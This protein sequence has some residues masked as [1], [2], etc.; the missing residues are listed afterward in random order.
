M[1]H[2]VHIT[3]NESQTFRIPLRYDTQ[4]TLRYQKKVQSVTWLYSC[5]SPHPQVELLTIKLLLNIKLSLDIGLKVSTGFIRLSRHQTSYQL[6]RQKPVT[7]VQ[8]I[9]MQQ[10]VGKKTNLKIHTPTY[11]SSSA[12]FSPAK[13]HEFHQLRK[14]TKNRTSSTLTNIKVKWEIMHQFYSDRCLDTDTHKQQFCVCHM[15]GFTV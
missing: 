11:N 4:N 14:S 3:A 8:L 7:G 10:C 12:D 2:Q 15:V 6:L 5:L 13:E 1:W 9:Q